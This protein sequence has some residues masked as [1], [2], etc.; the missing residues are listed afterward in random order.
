LYDEGNIHEIERRSETYDIHLKFWS[1]L[2]FL[3]LLL[4][5]FGQLVETQS[6]R[7]SEQSFQ[8]NGPV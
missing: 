5:I 6:R 8:G 1:Y 2:A 7:G 4:I 3:S